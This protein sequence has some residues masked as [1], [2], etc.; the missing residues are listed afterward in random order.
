MNFCGTISFKVFW[1]I[2]RV[3]VNQLGIMRMPLGLGDGRMDLSN[4]IW[5]GKKGQA[6]VEFEMARRLHSIQVKREEPENPWQ[7]C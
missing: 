3:R 1:T 4:S 6:R 2:W 5:G 7:N